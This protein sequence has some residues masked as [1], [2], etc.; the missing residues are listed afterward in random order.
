M[1]T[2]YTDAINVQPITIAINAVTWAQPPGAGWFAR[3]RDLNRLLGSSTHLL[4]LPAADEAEP[5]WY[6]GVA[7]TSLAAGID[8]MAITHESI[9]NSIV[10]FPLDTHI[11]VADVRQGLVRDEWVLYLD[12]FEARVNSWRE[13]GRTFT[14]LTGGGRQIVD[15]PNAG[16]LQVDIDT[17]AMTFKHASLALLS[18]GLVRWRDC[19]TTIAV[20]MLAF[21][22]SSTL[23]WWLRAPTIEPLQRVASLVTQEVTPPRHTASAELAVLAMLA[24]THD[25]ALWREHGVSQFHYNAERR[26]LELKTAD[27][28]PMS[29]PMGSLPVAPEPLPLVPYTLES[30]QFKL[31][32]HLNSPQWSVSFGDPYPIGI[33]SELEQHVTVAVGSVDESYQ[34]AVA[35][36]LVDLSERLVRLPITLYLVNCP[37][38][39]GMLTTCELKFAIRGASTS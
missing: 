27:G 22:I 6:A 34:V 8:L 23:N 32:D 12:G 14:L 20:L 3:C 29:T 1:A 5:V 19:L 33:G 18:A 11:Y 38:A 17:D 25:V 39:D 30:F 21:V 24:A 2:A 26:S 13:E 10:A 16:E 28:M 15:M 7:G 9:R 35:A 31:T 36:A 37:V 4:R